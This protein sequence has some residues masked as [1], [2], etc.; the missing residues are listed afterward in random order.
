MNLRVL[1][2]LVFFFLLAGSGAPVPAG[3]EAGAETGAEVEP[4]P[5]IDFRIKDQFEKLHTSGSFRNFVTILVSGDRKG[6][7]FIGDWSPVLE[8]SLAVEVKSYR[9]K[10]LPHAHL[11][12]VPFFLKGTVKNKFTQDGQEWVLMDWGGEF[13]KSYG[14]AEDH[15]NIVVFDREGIR[16]IQEAVQEFDPQVFERVLAGI[17]GL[18]E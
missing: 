18:E 3:A 16:R 9:V 13:R 14:L 6:S 5:L 12:G 17:R 1:G 10:F 7:A 4:L 2:A 15:C 8:D 11:K